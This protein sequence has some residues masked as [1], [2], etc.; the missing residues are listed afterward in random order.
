MNSKADEYNTEPLARVLLAVAGLLG[1]FIFLE[2]ATFFV[3]A[4][5]ADGIVAQARDTTLG[6]P[7]GPSAEVKAAVEG[8]KKNN[9]FAPA[10]SKQYP[11]SEVTGILG[12][13]ALINGQWYK[14]G[15]IVADARI[16]AIE[17]T[18]V[19]VV[20]NGQ[21]KEFMPIGSTGAGGPPGR[22][23]GRKGGPPGPRGAGMVVTGGQPGPGPGAVAGLSPE[24]RDQMRERFR[25]MSPEERQKYRDET[26]GR[27]GRRDR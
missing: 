6:R 20:W 26:R 11:I 5:D 25:G 21:E 10:A 15:D 24:E 4:A 12:S 17:P 23:P 19:K 7:A 1:A 18:K 22:S 16:L 2:V 8:L 9:L 3:R 14:A 13:Q 27:L